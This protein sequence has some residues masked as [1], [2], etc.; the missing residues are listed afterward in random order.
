MEAL[1]DLREGLGTHLADK[2][3]S[4]KRQDRPI[5]DELRVPLEVLWQGNGRHIR[6]MSAA[7]GWRPRRRK[8][9]AAITSTGGHRDI[10]S[11]S[12]VC[13]KAC[14][15][16]WP[17]QLPGLTKRTRVLGEQPPL[18]PVAGGGGNF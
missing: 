12:T 18:T 14:R 17:I 10:Q 15:N 3:E 9:T 7:A 4:S 16:R 5:C 13:R 8:R 11:H 6:E 1:L 2:R